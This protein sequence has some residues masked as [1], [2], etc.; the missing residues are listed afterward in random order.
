[1][2]TTHL[3][4]WKKLHYGKYKVTQD[5]LTNRNDVGKSVGDVPTET[6]AETKTNK[7]VWE[8]I[9]WDDYI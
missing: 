1:M 3:E 9:L 6:T 7:Q 2:V 4:R 5:Q 8:S